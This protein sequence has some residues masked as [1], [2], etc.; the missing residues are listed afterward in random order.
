ML[1]TLAEQ[2]RQ[3]IRRIRIFLSLKDPD[4]LVRGVAKNLI[5]KTEDTVMCLRVSYKKKIQKKLFLHP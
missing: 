1:Y 4:P 5:F 3:L 2:D